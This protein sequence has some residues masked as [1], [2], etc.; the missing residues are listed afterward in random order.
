MH[1][2]SELFFISQSN[3]EILTLSRDTQIVGIFHLFLTMLLLQLFHRLYK[4]S[5]A[6][7][8][9]ILVVEHMVSMA[10]RG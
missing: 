1:A 4:Q 8:L 3:W 5:T 10:N 9:T 2:T 6:I 7:S